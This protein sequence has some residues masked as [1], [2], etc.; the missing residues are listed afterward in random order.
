MSFFDRHPG[1]DD[2]LPPAPTE[3]KAALPLKRPIKSRPE[4]KAPG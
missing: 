4:P 2:D 3:S 1:K